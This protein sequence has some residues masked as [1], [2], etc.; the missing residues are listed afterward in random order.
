MGLKNRSAA[1]S[2]GT[3]LDHAVYR[4]PFRVYLLV[5]RRL[6][7]RRH[8]PSLS[9]LSTRIVTIQRWCIPGPLNVYWTRIYTILPKTVFRST[10]HS[11]G[12]LM[13]KSSSVTSSRCRLKR[14][15][16]APALPTHYYIP[17]IYLA[18]D[19]PLHDHTK[20]HFYEVEGL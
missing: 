8:L 9:C 15:R 14:T 18:A 19:L 3:M 13:T 1:A 6:M 16:Y 11:L 7:H 20:I 17:K 5:R 2:S 12:Y 10:K 4:L